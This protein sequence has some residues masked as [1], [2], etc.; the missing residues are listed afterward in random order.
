MTEYSTLAAVDL[1]FGGFGSGITCIMPVSLRPKSSK[2][3]PLDQAAHP[4]KGT[5]GA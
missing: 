3:R 1:G 2:P 5:D 4:R